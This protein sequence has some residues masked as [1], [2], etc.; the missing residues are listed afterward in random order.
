[1]R[2][3]PSQG[4]YPCSRDPALL[5][6]DKKCAFSHDVYRE[7][8]VFFISVLLLSSFDSSS[9]KRKGGTRERGRKD[10]A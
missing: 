5:R 6:D 1:M 3:G 10:K 7:E 9:P 4:N 2:G 8:T